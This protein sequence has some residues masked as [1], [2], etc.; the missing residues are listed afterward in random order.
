MSNRELVIDVVSKLPEDTPIEDIL[1][2]IAFVAGVNEAIAEADRGEVITLEELK[3]QM[4]QW[5]TE[6]L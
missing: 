5:D 4:K 6:S 1:E 2:R 3:K